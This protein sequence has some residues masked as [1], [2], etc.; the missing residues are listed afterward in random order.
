MLIHIYP[1]NLSDI[2]E[3]PHV[4]NMKFCCSRIDF[5][6][7]GYKSRDLSMVYLIFREIVEMPERN[8]N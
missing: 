2:E 1:T 6:G 3:C 4:A 5:L 8:Y 7:N